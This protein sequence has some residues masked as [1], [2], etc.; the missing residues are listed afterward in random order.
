MKIQKSR[1]EDL[2]GHNRRDDRRPEGT[3][4]EQHRSDADASGRIEER[5]TDC[6]PK[7]GPGQDGAQAESQEHQ[8][9]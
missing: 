2:A 5:R 1:D 7:R 4:G 9:K 6:G 3:P 8:G